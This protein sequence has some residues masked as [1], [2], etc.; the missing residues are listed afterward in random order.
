M[1]RPAAVREWKLIHVGPASR[2]ARIVQPNVAVIPRAASRA[3]CCLTHWWRS[4]AAITGLHADP[5]TPFDTGDRATNC[6][7]LRRPNS[8]HRGSRAGNGHSDASAV[9]AS[10]A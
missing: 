5:A 8:G 10:R 6:S 3:L 7:A 9:A 1:T 2:P 4:C